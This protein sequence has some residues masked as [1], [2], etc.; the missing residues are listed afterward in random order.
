LGRKG[1][2]LAE[3]TRLNHLYLRANGGRW[4]TLLEEGE[5]ILSRHPLRDIHFGE[6]QPRAEFCEN[7]MVLAA[8]AVTPWG[9]VRVFVT[10]LANRDAEVNRA[11][12]GSRM[13]FVTSG[14]HDL[15]IIV[16]DFNATDDAPQIR[17]ISR[18][19]VDAYRGVHPKAAGPTYCGHPLLRL[20]PVFG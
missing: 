6:P 16:S 12:A 2:H 18:Q 1:D 4:A 11:D 19:A 7:R 20:R 17:E 3:R 5:G 10:R 14:S 13:A 15:A 8:T 9:K